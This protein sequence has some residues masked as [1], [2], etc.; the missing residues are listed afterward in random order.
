MTLVEKALAHLYAQAFENVFTAQISDTSVQ[1]LQQAADALAAQSSVSFYLGLTVISDAQKEKT[2]ET[3]FTSYGCAA[4]LA[5]LLKLLAQHKRL[6]LIGE[7]V[8]QII[9]VYQERHGIVE[10][11]LKTA[12]PLSAEQQKF[13]EQYL[14]TSTAKKVHLTQEIDQTLIAGIRVE[15]AQW[16][17]E[18]SVAQQL[19][20]IRALI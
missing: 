8:Q 7:V 3:F 2:L 6:F 14:C 10:A 13:I 9:A 11:Q 19:R 20:A 17:W 15:S 5:P 16:L 4:L 18:Y 12:Q 1:H